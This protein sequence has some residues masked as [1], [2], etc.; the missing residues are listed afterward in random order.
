MPTF[1]KQAVTDSINSVMSVTRTVIKNFAYGIKKNSNIYQPEFSG[2][3][4]LKI[5]IK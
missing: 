1:E 4:S 5:F 2:V 3:Y